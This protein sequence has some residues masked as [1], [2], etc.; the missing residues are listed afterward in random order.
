MD[1]AIVRGPRAR[2]DWKLLAMAAQPDAWWSTLTD[3]LLR[4]THSPADTER[5]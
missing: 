1:R 4:P 2:C 5:Q 3:V